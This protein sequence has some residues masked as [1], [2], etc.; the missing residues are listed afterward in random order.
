MRMFLGMAE[1]L[2]GKSPQAAAATNDDEEPKANFN[3]SEEDEE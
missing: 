2:K 3:Y 1:E